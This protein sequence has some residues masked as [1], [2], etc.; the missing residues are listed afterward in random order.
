M[1]S[2]EWQPPAG[3]SGQ[4]DCAQGSR[5]SPVALLAICA[6]RGSDGR[7][8]SYRRIHPGRK[9]ACHLPGG[10]SRFLRPAPPGPGGLICGPGTAHS[11]AGEDHAALVTVRA[12]LALA[13]ACIE[14][15]AQRGAVAKGMCPLRCGGGLP[16]RCFGD[17][18]NNTL[19]ATVLAAASR[20]R[21]DPDPPD[22]RHGQL[23]HGRSC[24]EG[25]LG[26]L[27]QG[28]CGVA[29]AVYPALSALS[30]R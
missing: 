10:P 21:R 12:I 3:P 5:T 29:V 9:V 19:A 16:R 27:A 13:D 18:S 17:R 26:D 30:L 14:V 28:V 1:S 23:P 22:L 4:T 2:R 15:A 20:G 25:V 24:L 7:I 11:S 6:R 8:N